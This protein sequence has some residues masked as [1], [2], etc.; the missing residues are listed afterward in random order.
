MFNIT[1]MHDYLSVIMLN[2]WINS[3]QGGT[4]NV[5]ILRFKIN[6][7]MQKANRACNGTRK[8]TRTVS[9]LD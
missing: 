1:S 5:N 2:K 7:R 8:N 3:I 6:M 4:K 9:K